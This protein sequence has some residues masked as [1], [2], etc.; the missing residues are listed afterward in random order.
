MVEVS[1]WFVAEEA[2]VA[3]LTPTRTYKSQHKSHDT[4]MRLLHQTISI[5]VDGRV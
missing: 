4:R 1:E 3:L 5:Y 2:L